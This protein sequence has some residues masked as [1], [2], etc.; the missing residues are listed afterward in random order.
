MN[1]RVVEAS[2]DLLGTK[3]PNTIIRIGNLGL[4]QMRRGNYAGAEANILEAHELIHE[5]FDTDVYRKIW[6]TEIK[7]NVL[8]LVGKFDA[9]LEAYDDMMELALDGYGPNSWRHASA[10]RARGNWH[11]DRAEYGRAL[12]I[13]ERATAIAAA[14]DTDTGRNIP[15]AAI[16]IAEAES[17]LG[18]FAAAESV[19]RTALATADTLP[20]ATRLH[21]E[22]E[23]AASISRQGRFEEA[24]PMILDAVRAHEEYG[25]AESVVMLPVLVAA[26]GHFRRMEEPD[27]ALT[28][29]A[30]AG[31]IAATITPAGNWHAAL[32]K[33]EQGRALAAAGRATEAAPLLRQAAADLEATF[34]PRDPRVVTLHAELV[35]IEADDSI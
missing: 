22:I 4:V 8:R 24:T 12:E 3:N 2:R 10:L 16:R 14:L 25:G 34:G 23:L 21:L 6:I 7:G 15:R 18:D 9:A 32:A 26:S 19:A 1:E 17:A 27:R 11:A 20:T 5:V 33:A 28:Y 31:T 29:A 13:L 30:R 35:R